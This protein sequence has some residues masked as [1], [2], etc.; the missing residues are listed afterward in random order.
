MTL[1]GQH[2]AVFLREHLPRDR[3]A[4]PHTCEAYATCFQ[5]LVVFAAS[6]LRTRPS[7]LTVEEIDAT[8]VL[9]FLEHLATARKRRSVA[10]RAAGRNQRLLPLP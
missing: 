3:G 8:L 4:S 9:A 1:L 10:Q 7:D 2:L 6:H 5:L